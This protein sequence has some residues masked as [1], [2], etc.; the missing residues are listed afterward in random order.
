MVP[1]FFQTGQTRANKHAVLRQKQYLPRPEKGR[2]PG[3][4]LPWP[5]AGPGRSGSGSSLLFFLSSAMSISVTCSCGAKLKAPDDA[6]G[7]AVA[8]PK[9]KARL[10]VPSPAPAAVNIGPQSS[11]KT[12][13]LWPTCLLRFTQ[14]RQS[15]R[16]AYDLTGLGPST[17]GRLIAA[18]MLGGVFLLG[19]LLASL[20]LLHL[21]PMHGF[22]LAALAFGAVVIPSAI[23]IVWSPDATLEDTHRRALE[24]LR[25]RRR[26]R[27]EFEATPAGITSAEN[28]APRPRSIE[29]VTTQEC[30]YYAAEIPIR[31]LKCKHCGEFVDEESRP[32]TAGSTPGA[33]VEVHIHSKERKWS[34]GVAAVLSFL[35]PGLGQMYKGQI[36]NGLFWLFIVIPFGYVL[37]AFC[38]FI[39]GIILHLLCILGAASGDPY[40]S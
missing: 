11:H 31:A 25:V 7:K 23:L 5:L 4:V 34:P 18:L 28:A 8:C 16:K 15:T 22:L 6:A 38:F 24:E 17:L 1:A 32:K 9:C 39:P 30:P 3:A 26:A 33:Q 14:F 37:G 21:E 2:R 27:K 20:L 40:R 19:I 10:T 29:P 36:F 13:T 35:I 12:S